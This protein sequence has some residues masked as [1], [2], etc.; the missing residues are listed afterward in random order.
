MNLIKVLRCRFQHCLDTFTMLLVEGFSQTGLF[1][2]LSDHDSGVRNIGY[3]KSVR[4]VFFFWQ[5]LKLIADFKNLAKNSENIFCF[6]DNCIWIGIVKL[7]LLR[8]GYFSSAAN[9]LPSSPRMWSLKNRDFFQLN[10][11][12]SDQSIW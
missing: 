5:Y 3:T 9:V 4:V 2:H 10:W 8:T 7:S 6:W 11:I 12:G 1:R